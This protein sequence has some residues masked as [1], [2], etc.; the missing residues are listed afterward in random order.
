MQ[1]S[2][3]LEFVLYLIYKFK[4]TWGPVYFRQSSLVGVSKD[5]E[6]SS[7]ISYLLD[8]YGQPIICERVLT[9]VAGVPTLLAF[10]ISN[11]PAELPIKKPTVS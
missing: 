8:T 2:L 6:V 9:G 1:L 10:L 11:C 4:E 7:L 5:T 3:T